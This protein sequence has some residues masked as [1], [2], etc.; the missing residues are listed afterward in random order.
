MIV[1]AVVSQVITPNLTH[2]SAHCITVHL[3]YHFVMS[4]RHHDIKNYFV[5]S[6]VRLSVTSR[7]C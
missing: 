1:S 3:F 4:F 7:C 5:C 2:I 6:S